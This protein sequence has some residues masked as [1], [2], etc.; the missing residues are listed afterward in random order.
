MKVRA[1]V[2][3]AVSAACL[4]VM[5]PAAPAFAEEPPLDSTYLLYVGKDGERCRVFPIT[6]VLPERA[7]LQAI[8]IASP[9]THCAFRS[10]W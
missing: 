5:I 4:G 3:S 7:R 6:A 9:P 2:G 10:R 8:K 1:I